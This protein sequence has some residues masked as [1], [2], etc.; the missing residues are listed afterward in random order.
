DRAHERIEQAENQGHD[1]ELPPL[2]SESQPGQQFHRGEDRDGCE[3]PSQKQ[4]HNLPS[5]PAAVSGDKPLIS[6]RRP[7]VIPPHATAKSHVGVPV[8][9]MSEILSPR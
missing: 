7:L 6:C 8:L 2:A 4:L 1:A 5:I 9:P 3:Y